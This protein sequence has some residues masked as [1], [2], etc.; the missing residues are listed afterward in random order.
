MNTKQLIA[1]M[2]D[3]LGSK[4]KLGPAATKYAR[5][6]SKQAM[7]PEWKPKAYMDMVAEITGQ[8]DRKKGF[9][10]KDAGQSTSG[11]KT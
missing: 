11:G 2:R 5:M 8:Q 1:E 10:N 4:V 7:T 9:K 6:T 3:D